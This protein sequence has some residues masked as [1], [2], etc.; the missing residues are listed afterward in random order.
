MYKVYAV[1]GNEIKLANSF[2]TEKGAMLYIAMFG[3]YLKEQGHKVKINERL[4]KIDGVS[5]VYF[6]APSTLSVF[7]KNDIEKIK[8]K[9]VDILTN[10]RL[11]DT[12]EKINFYKE[13][14][15]L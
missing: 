4:E 9:V 6:I 10:L 5:K 1:R 7:Y 11:M 2:D 8:L 12:F 13:S 3:L 14:E 15:E